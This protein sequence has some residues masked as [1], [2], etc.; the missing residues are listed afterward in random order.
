M[1]NL[2]LIAD[3][4]LR[5]M[6]PF[7]SELHYP[8]KNAD[9]N[10]QDS[11]VRTPFFHKFD[12]VSW[13]TQLPQKMPVTFNQDGESE[14]CTY[15]ADDK[16]DYLLNSY[17]M[18]PLPALR[19]REKYKDK[20]QIC[21][22]HNVGHNIYE[23]AWLYIDNQMAARFDNI[24]LD[25]VSQYYQTKRE[26]Y[27]KSI[28]NVGFLTNWNT[29]LPAYSL[30]IQQPW[31]YTKPYRSLPLLLC[32][33]DKV[34]HKYK[35]RR[36]LRNL[37]R[38][39]RKKDDGSW[40]EIKCNT[41]FIEGIK[42]DKIPI[43]ELW[44]RYA[45]ISPEERL[46]LEGKDEKGKKVVDREYVLYTDDVLPY[47]S[48]NSERLGTTVNV[49]ISSPLP[50]RAFFWVAENE[51][52]KS[53]N[54]LSNYTTNKTDI[55][56]GWSPIDKVSMTRGTVTRIPQMS[57]GHF[58]NIEAIRH[59]P[60]VPYDPGYGAYSA[61]YDTTSY[62]AEVGVALDSKYQNELCFVLGNTDP[63]LTKIKHVKTEN[64]REEDAPEEDEEKEEIV[65][66]ND[67]ATKYK[68]SIHVRLLIMRKIVFMYEKKVS[69]ST[70]TIT[71][72]N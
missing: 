8:P 1:E 41:S 35:L 49:P 45:L 29:F 50:V 34:K 24:W 32:K 39:R 38:M 40:E 71:N 62:N 56:L 72:M 17:H 58:G 64:G 69:I 15:E 27:L 21:W 22:P 11:T 28:G 23:E 2:H 4:D 70:G 14:V 26:P 12:R 46:W 16:F 47:K 52:S 42:D 13:S 36:D 6:T 67:P 18:Q 5:Q 33:L 59:F 63:N 44:G 53:I 68:Y 61:S 57:S 43:P 25:E 19:V 30:Y 48:T 54:N 66:D 51:S 31:F 37:L 10:S 7:Q 55:S 20:Y 65:V 60:M 3:L 9:K